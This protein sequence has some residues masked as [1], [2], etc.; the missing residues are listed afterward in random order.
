MI[1]IHALYV[2]FMCYFCAD[3]MVNMEGT[4]I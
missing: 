4:S 3:F 1:L 2:S